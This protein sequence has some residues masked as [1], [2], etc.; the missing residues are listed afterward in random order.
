MTAPLLISMNIFKR[1]Q[2]FIGFTK[3]EQK[4]F[5]FISIIFIIGISIKVYKAYFVHETIPQFDYSAADKEFQQ[6][7]SSPVDSGGTQRWQ[8]KNT[9]QLTAVKVNLN[10]AT[11]QEL[12]SLPGIGAGLAERILDYR[13][14]NGNFS[15]VDELKKV[16]GIGKKKFDKLLPY[17]TTQ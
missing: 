16:S 7:S 13:K 1:I 2:D 14:Q 17:I 9:L 4:I 11:K 3:N 15:A 10:S 5:L 6:R 12:I 8:S